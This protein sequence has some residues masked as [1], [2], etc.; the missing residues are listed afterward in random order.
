[1]SNAGRDALVAMLSRLKNDLMGVNLSK[2]DVARATLQTKYPLSGDYMLEVRRLCQRGIDEGWLSQSAAGDTRTLRVAPQSKHFPFAIEAMHLAGEGV[3]HGHP[4][5]E[6]SVG[7]AIDGSPRFCGTE[8]GWAACAPGSKHV[9]EVR[10]GTM[11]LLHFLPDGQID[12]DAKVRGAA[13]PRPRGSAM[14]AN[15]PR[16]ASAVRA[17]RAVGEQR[18]R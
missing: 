6:I 18:G 8:P 1:M 2:P 9:P 17:R 14:L 5:G 11:F 13:R 12:W 15:A 10:G 16:A 3:G 7:W 4:K